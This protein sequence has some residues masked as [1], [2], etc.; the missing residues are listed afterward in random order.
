M[1]V[2]FSKKKKIYCQFYFI[3]G[4]TITGQNKCLLVLQAICID[5]FLG[6]QYRFD[7]SKCFPCIK[8]VHR[9]EV[10]TF[11]KFSI[12]NFKFFKVVISFLIYIIVMMYKLSCL[13]CLQISLIYQG[14]KNVLNQLRK[15]FFMQ[16]ICSFL[17][18]QVLQCPRLL[19]P[20]F[21]NTVSHYC[22][23]QN[24]LGLGMVRR[25]HGI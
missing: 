22:T 4:Y 5:I 1:L 13:F 20:P 3:I 10:E 21:P 7:F 9:K 16:L 24:S 17:C 2:V 19:L 23:L 15:C 14:L 12:A 11:V 8:Y 25:S 6:F 18:G